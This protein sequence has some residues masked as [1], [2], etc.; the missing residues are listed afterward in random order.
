MATYLHTRIDFRVPFHDVDPAGIVWHGR[1]FKYLE[2]ARCAL[3]DHIGYGYGEMAA[4]G[5][6]WPMLDVKARYLRPAVYDQALRV[7]ASLTDWDYCLKIEYEIRDDSAEVITR[8]TTTQVPVLATTRK[9]VLG[10]PPFVVA[11]IE[12]AL[13]REAAS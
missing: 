12:A 6:V 10:V 1:Y 5:Y 13:E 8:A 11:L 3:L 9:M 7:D 4:S 2:L